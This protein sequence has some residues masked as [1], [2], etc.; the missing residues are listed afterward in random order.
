[1]ETSIEP[2]KKTDYW[3]HRCGCILKREEDW[4]AIER[5]CATHTPNYDKLVIKMEKRRKRKRGKGYTKSN[6]KK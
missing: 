1:M 4:W 6:K 5:R 3:N 2:P